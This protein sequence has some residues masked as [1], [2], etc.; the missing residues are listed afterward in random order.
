MAPSRTNSR[1]FKNV[2]QSFSI[3]VRLN[4]A[5]KYFTITVNQEWIVVE[6]RAP[7]VRRWRVKKKNEKK[8]TAAPRLSAVRPSSR[9]FTAVLACFVLDARQFRFSSAAGKRTNAGSRGASVTVR[10]RVY[11]RNFS[12]VRLLGVRRRRWRAG[13]SW[14]RGSPVERGSNNGPR[15]KCNRRPPL[16]GE[17]PFRWPTEPPDVSYVREPRHS[18]AMGKSVS[19]GDGEKQPTSPN[20]E[21][22]TK[23]E[24][25]TRRR[26]RSCLA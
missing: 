26:G 13:E 1:M 4:V 2:L 9:S 23:N 14:D 8:K 12:G 21:C 22:A 17:R 7:S 25:T 6:T 19:T 11:M 20:A 18:R 24:K 3:V 10:W 5:S 15:G 16:S